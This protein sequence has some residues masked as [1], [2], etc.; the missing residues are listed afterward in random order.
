[1]SIFPWIPFSVSAGISPPW[2]DRRVLPLRARA[3]DL[4]AFVYRERQRSFHYSRECQGPPPFRGGHLVPLRQGSCGAAGRTLAGAAG[5]IVPIPPIGQEPAGALLSA[6][7]LFVRFS[8]SCRRDARPAAAA[9]AATA[10]TGCAARSFSRASYSSAVGGLSVVAPGAITLALLSPT[11]EFDRPVD[12][13]SVNVPACVSACAPAR[14]PSPLRRSRARRPASCEGASEPRLS[15]KP[16]QL[17]RSPEV[18]ARIKFVDFYRFARCF[19]ASDFIPLPNTGIRFTNPSGVGE[20][21]ASLG[22]FGG[23]RARAI[24]VLFEEGKS[25]RSARTTSRA[26]S[27]APGTWV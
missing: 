21:I 7:R 16:S 11:F 6:R 5:A 23:R 26:R 9:A 25:A 17:S 18:S 19:S 13:S 1:M 8:F 3:R 24:Y 14:L 27:E 2:Q 20:R 4:A 12:H 15:S 10:A 22:N